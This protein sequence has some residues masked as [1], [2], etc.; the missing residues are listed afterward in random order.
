MNDNTFATIYD[1]LY[2]ASVTSNKELSNFVINQLYLSTN[3]DVD[4]QTALNSYI[5]L[6]E[7]VNEIPSPGTLV[8]RNIAFSTARTIDENS[9]EDLT[10]IFLLNK[11]K[12]KFSSE[13]TNI[14]MDVAKPGNTLKDAQDKL[15]SLINNYEISSNDEEHDDTFNEKILE[16]MK[17][18]EEIKGV[19]FGIEAIDQLYPGTASGSLTVIGGY[20]GSLKTT[21]TL[22]HCFIAMQEGKNSLYFSLEVNKQDI[23]INLMSLYTIKCTNEPIKRSDME[24]LRFKDPDKFDSIFRQLIS[25]PG[26]I[27][28]YDETDFEGYSQSEFNRIIRL[29]DKRF[30]EEFNSGLDI[31]VLDHAQL[32]KYDD[33]SSKDPYQ[34]L[35]NWVHFFRTKASRDGF[36]VI[37]V[38]QTSR[39]G[40]EYAS[41]HGGQYLL[42]GL[43]EGNELERGTTFVVAIYNSEDLKASGQ[44][45]IQILK[46]RY[47]E[48]MLEPQ[49]VNVRP[50]Y[51][52]IGDGYYSNK[53]QQIEAVFKDEDVPFN[54]FTQNNSEESQDLDS[55][56]SGM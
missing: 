45:Q 42:T 4:E 25:L 37:L 44:V 5:A 35:N 11:T 49:L 41:K 27:Q 32:L 56:L 17:N 21:L 36:A 9:L 14:V 46:N 31:I 26:H 54:P 18:T 34:V 29:T 28:V 23:M 15:L 10:N 3:L 19:P 40:Y 48:T 16:K 39:G 2:S 12:M 8:S 7:E 52:L 24:K 53:T 47:G 43:A 20:A 55:L 50:E 38:S 1:L 6:K 51:Y 30:R 33:K 13:V 22:N